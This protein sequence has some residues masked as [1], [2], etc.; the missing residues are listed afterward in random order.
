MESNDEK[1]GCRQEILIKI[2]SGNL[3]SNER[4]NLV[5][6]VFR[7]AFAPGTLTEEFLLE[8]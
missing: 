5:G 8:S 4:V 2:K 1:L 7:P 3:F 6:K